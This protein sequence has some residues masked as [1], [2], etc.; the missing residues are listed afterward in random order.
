MGDWKDQMKPNGDKGDIR[1]GKY[2]FMKNYR[3]CY[4][5]RK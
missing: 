3:K 1:K 2:L 4:Y 5:V